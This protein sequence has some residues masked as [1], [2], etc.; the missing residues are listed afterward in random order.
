[1]IKA[2]IFCEGLDHPECVA[3][4]ADRSI[5]AGGE[6][7]QIYRISH[8]GQNVE[9]VANTGGFIL[10]IAFHPNMSW[11]AICDLHNKC[12][13]KLDLSTFQLSV[14]ASGA[15]GHE[16]NIP[17]Y[18]VFD[19]EGNLYVSESGAF[20]EISGKILKF[21]PDGKGEIWHSGPFNFANGLA[22]SPDHKYLFVVCSW[23]PGVEKISIESDGRAGER[24]VYCTLPQTVPDGI[25]F[26][27]QGN[28]YTSCYTPNV[29]YK[30]QTDQT[31]NVFLE[32]WEGH[33]LSNPTNIAFRNN[34][35]LF[36]ANLGRWHITK[37]D[38]D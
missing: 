9:I 17:N 21:D 4:H 32:D 35:E 19:K 13:W 24:Q 22:I 8:D 15:E 28:L 3:V 11:L 26:D 6:A 5:W 10:G 16:F 18:A 14:F 1:M 23:L 38:L 34:K 37:I 25:A 20:R 27:Q 7:G 31:T 33:T 30:T 2:D 36:S 12:I 29:I